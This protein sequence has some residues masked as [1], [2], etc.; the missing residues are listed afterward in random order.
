MKKVLIAG[1]LA[2]LFFNVQGQKTKD[3]VFKNGEKGRFVFEVINDTTYWGVDALPSG[4]HIVP[5]QYGK[6]TRYGNLLYC[7]EKRGGTKYECELFDYLGNCKIKDGD[8]YKFIEYT[9]IDGVELFS[10]SEVHKD[11][12]LDS[13]GNFLYKYKSVRDSRGFYSLVNELADTV[14]VETGMYTSPFSIGNGVILTKIGEKIGVLSRDGKVIIPATTYRSVLPWNKGGVLKGFL[15]GLSSSNGKRGFVDAKGKLII[16]A[17]NYTDVYVQEDGTFIVRANGKEGVIDSLGNV[18]F[19]SKYRSIEL[20]K[21]SLGNLYYLTYKGDGRGKMDYSGRIINEPK[22]TT[23]R[24]EEKRNGFAYVKVS[25]TSG[26]DGIESTDG[27]TILPCEYNLVVY[28]DK[29]PGFYLHKNGYEGYADIKGN[30]IIP[31]DRY[32][33]VSTVWMPYF[34]VESMGKEGLCDRTGRELIAPRYDDV[35]PLKDGYVVVKDGIMEGAVDYSGKMLV[36]IEYTSV[37]KRDGYY[38]VKLFGKEGVVDLNGR[39]IVP[40]M[41]KSVYPSDGMYRVVDDGGTE[42]YYN[43]DGTMVFPTGLFKNVFITDNKGAFNVR[44]KTVIQAYNKSGE[45]YYYDMRG[46]LLRSPED[47][48]KYDELYEQAG[49]QFDKKNYRKAIKLYEEALGYKQT[50]SAYYNIGAA[51]Y[52]LSDYK[53]AKQSLEKCLQY[54]SYIKDK[55]NDLIY[56]CNMC[57]QK[58]RERRAQFWTGLAIGALDVAGTI[59]MSN[60]ATQN[61]NSRAN[62]GTTPASLDPNLI[63]QQTIVQTNMQMAQQKQ[64][65]MSQF[66]ASFRAT[67]GR[68]PSQE[69]EMEAYTQYLRSLNAANTSYSTENSSSSSSS[70]S[71]SQSSSTSTG[72]GPSRCPLCSGSG[73]TVEYA[74]T[75]GLGENKYCKDCGKTVAGGHYH[76]TCKMCGGKGVK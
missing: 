23:K 63:M 16:P 75:F 1:L 42:G 71:S 24:K 7:K 54:D 56:E 34:V 27:K 55:A 46:K 76:Q 30:V 50:A 3:F 66:R 15:V 8:G 68:N 18:K 65:F 37:W 48:K 69:E 51:Y 36:P 12:I 40:P 13:A 21:D 73:T 35:R 45:Y 61:Y 25:D 17:V 19:M 43:S 32:D 33:R 44:D 31:P 10:F 41:Y 28:D 62:R 64:A 67:M 20:K 70:S 5:I 59:A 72:K 11:A 52:N 49:V 26:F 14:V 57:I 9:I 29:F 4:R 58:K 2:A 39:Q 22:P 53:S 74:P 47:Q 6:I 60:M 38:N